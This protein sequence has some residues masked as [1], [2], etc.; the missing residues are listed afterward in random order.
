MSRFDASDRESGMTLVE[1][2]VAASTGVVVM[3]GISL[4]LIVTIRDSRRVSSHIQANQQARLTMAKVTDQLHSACVAYNIAPIQES[5]GPTSIT[6]LH[7]IGSA[8]SPTP[9]KS[10]I[11]LSGTDLVQTDYAATGGSAPQWTFATS[12]SSTTTLVRRISAISASVPIFRY[13]AFESGQISATPLTT[14]LEEGRNLK[15]VQVDVAFK[16]APAQTVSN[17]AGAAAPIQ[18]SVLLRFTPA[19][20]ETSAQNLP[21][22]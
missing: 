6:F 11:A 12:A 7:Q 5:S 8:V 13:Y 2:L 3:L 1:L 17:D 16:V 10:T 22:Q 20:F 19:N 18:S 21:C 9:V 15:A 14:P 4:A